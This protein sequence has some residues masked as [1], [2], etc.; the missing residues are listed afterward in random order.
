[1][2]LEALSCGEEEGRHCEGDAEAKSQDS[3]QKSSHSG[4]QEAIDISWFR[5]EGYF[6][7]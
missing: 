2:Y 3:P 4:E 5:G 1:M 6:N 7:K